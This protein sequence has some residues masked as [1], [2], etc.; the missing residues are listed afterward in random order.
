MTAGQALVGISA[1]ALLVLT[2]SGLHMLQV[3]LERWASNR[4]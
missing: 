1:T 2:A 3:R 4:H